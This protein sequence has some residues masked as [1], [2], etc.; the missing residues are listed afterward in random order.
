[1]LNKRVRIRL[2][3][4]Y[5]YSPSDNALIRFAYMLLS[6]TSQVFKFVSKDGKKYKYTY[7]NNRYV[8][9]RYYAK[10][11]H[12]DFPKGY[13]WLLVTLTVRRDIPLCT[14][15][16]NIGSWVSAFLNAL[17]TY[18]YRRKVKIP[19]FWVIEPHK[20][21]YPHVHIL[22]AFPFLPIEKLLSWWAY[23]DPQ[24]VDVRFIGSDTQ[25][26]RNYVIKYLLKGQYVDFAIDYKAGFIEFGII[27]FLLY[28]NRVRLLGRSRGFI[29][30][31][32][33]KVSD[34][35]FIGR[36]DFVY[37]TLYDLRERLDSLKIDYDTKELKSLL[38]SFLQSSSLV[39][40]YRKHD[41]EPIEADPVLPE[42]IDF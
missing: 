13:K 9:P 21:G 36:A 40:E 26:V 18:F 42:D 30:R 37:D 31:E 3:D 25:Q 33:K 32:L 22:I 16:A 15:W 38:T 35:V 20:D 12:L 41:I 17:R 8:N 19:Y 6:L 10:Y 14:A 29:L 2:E 23:S 11:K 7:A 24:G 34:W 28:Y 27:P 1:M 39:F 5:K 4:L